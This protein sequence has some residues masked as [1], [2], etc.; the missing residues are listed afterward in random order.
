MDDLYSGL[1]SS[2]YWRIVVWQL[3]F[4]NSSYLILTLPNFISE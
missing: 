4:E 1:D 2:E 3:R